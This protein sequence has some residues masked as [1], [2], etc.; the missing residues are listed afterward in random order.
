MP[1]CPCPFQNKHTDFWVISVCSVSPFWCMVSRMSWSSCS[2]HGTWGIDRNKTK[3]RPGIS[4]RPWRP[5]PSLSRPWCPFKS[6]LYIHVDF[7]IVKVEVLFAKWKWPCPLKDSIPGLNKN[8]NGRQGNGGVW[9]TWLCSHLTLQR[10]HFLSSPSYEA[11]ALRKCQPT[12]I[13]W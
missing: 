4:R 1:R 11:V 2:E 12:P 6:S 3:D 13:P 7:K 5:Q 8:L 10:L 9:C